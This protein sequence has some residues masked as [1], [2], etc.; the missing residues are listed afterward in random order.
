MGAQGWGQG[1]ATS[2]PSVMRQEMMTSKKTRPLTTRI[3][4]SSSVSIIWMSSVA[5]E[6]KSSAGS[7]SRPTNAERPLASAAEKRPDL[8]HQ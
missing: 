2:R 1:E 6:R 4:Q 7:D 8:L 3:V 5:I